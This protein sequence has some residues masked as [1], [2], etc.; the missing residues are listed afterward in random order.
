MIA[1]MKRPIS[2]SIDDALYAKV[3]KA[4]TTKGLK[5]AAIIEQALTLWLKASAKA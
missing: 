2:T 1:S 4:A 3:K 5:V